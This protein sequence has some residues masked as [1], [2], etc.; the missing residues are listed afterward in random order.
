MLCCLLTER[1]INKAKHNPEQLAATHGTLS[2]TLLCNMAQQ[3]SQKS[4]L[5]FKL[6]ILVPQT[7][8]LGYSTYML[9]HCFLLIFSL[10]WETPRSWYHGMVSTF[11]VTR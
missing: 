7:L 1:A 8:G 5:A 2:G 6:K 9:P 4:K 10:G 3:I 11:Y